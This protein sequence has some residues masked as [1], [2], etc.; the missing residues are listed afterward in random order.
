M[1]SELLPNNKFLDWS[2]L[3][4]FADDKLNVTQK[5]KF[6]LGLVENAGKGENA[7]YQHYLL[8]PLC[9][10]KPSF[11]GSFKVGIVW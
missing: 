6:L 4:A 9:F 5:T 2:R 1:K 11:L 10:R 3:E 8:A 7:G